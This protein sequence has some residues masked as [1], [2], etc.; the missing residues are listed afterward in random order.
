MDALMRRER[1]LPDLLD[2]FDEPLAAM[3]SRTWQSMR[4]DDYVKDGRYVLRVELP[5]IDPGKEVEIDLTNGVLTV[6]AE[7]REE[8]RVTRR[9]EGAQFVSPS[10]GHPYPARMDDYGSP[11]SAACGRRWAVTA[12]S[13][14]I[15]ANA[16]CG[17]RQ[18]ANIRLI[19]TVLTLPCEESGPHGG[20]SRWSSD[21][22]ARAYLVG[23]GLIDA[24]HD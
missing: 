14:A 21:G 2:R 6:H 7:R 20:S 19:K 10:R 22:Q 23:A 8:H 11:I 5:G 13:S 12:C 18:R 17:S 4:F 9:A 15:R 3:R 1:F 24:C 16:L